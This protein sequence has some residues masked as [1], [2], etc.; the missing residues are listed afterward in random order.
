M[1]D[2]GVH[3]ALSID[4]MV[5]VSYNAVVNEMRGKP[6][7]QWAES[8]FMQEL[9]SGGYIEY[10]AG[11]HTIEKS[12][13][14]KRNDGAD[15]QASDLA[16]FSTSKTDVLTAAQFTPAQVTVPIVWSRADEA[17]NSSENQKISL[18]KSLLENAL[19]S[20]DD[21]FEEALFEADTEGF[22]GLPGIM[23]DSGQGTI[24]GIDASTEAWWRHYSS[25]YASNYTTLI[26]TWTTAWNTAAKASGAKLTPKLIVT[27]AATHAGYESTQTGNIRYMN[28]ASADAGFLKLA[29]KKAGVIFSQYGDDHAY[30]I[31]PKTF[32]L[33]VFK[34]AYRELGEKAKFTNS[35]GYVRDIFSMAQCVTGN[36]SRLAVMRSA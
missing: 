4:Q 33:I 2:K 17:K 3:M 7:N 34:N 6:E 15:F 35:Q 32:K 24:G 11:S 10:V 25:T 31:G 28:T 18:V 12:L 19:E 14:Y 36:K 30:F 5:T 23:P 16:T 29:F 8:A 13:D 21:L 22:L 27:G 9:E 26:A 20:H 1:A